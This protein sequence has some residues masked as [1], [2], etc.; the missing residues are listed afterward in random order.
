MPKKLTDFS[1]DLFS[2]KGKIAMITGANQGLGMAYAIAFAT[3]GADIFI[4]HF[5]DDVSEIKETIEGLGRKVAFLQGDLTDG[6]YRKKVVEACVSVF[7]KIDILVNNAGTNF[8]APMLDFP[9][10]KWKQVLD[11]QLNAVYYLSREVAPVMVKNGGGK[12]INIAS[13]LSFAADI[14]ATAYTIAKH[15]IVGATRSFATELGGF[16]IQCNALA[17]GFFESEMNDM[18]RREN[19][20]LAQKV[21]DR[22]PGSGGR[23]GDISALM[24]PALFLASAASDYVNGDVLVVD[25]GFKAAMA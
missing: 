16:N 4:P 21:S 25:G 14:N 19:P 6:D 20:G 10:E 2:L 8:A 5:T 9:N 15:G 23:W 3:A 13:A 24:G 18:I 12:I 7:G 1:L 17:P 22:I 11:L